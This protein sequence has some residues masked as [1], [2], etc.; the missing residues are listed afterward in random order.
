MF[1]FPRVGKIILPLETDR[2]V[3]LERVNRFVVKILFRG[4]ETFAH[5][6]ETGRLSEILKP[7]TSLLLREKNSGK[8]K[9]EVVAGWREGYGWIL[10]NSGFHNYIVSSLLSHSEQEIKV[11]R[12]RIDF[13]VGNTLIEVKGVT[14]FRG[15]TALFPDAPTE[16]GRKHVEII[17]KE[18]GMVIFLL[19]NP[20]PHFIVP[21]WEK[22]S[23]FGS[24]LVS[25]V[26]RCVDIVG[27]KVSVDSEGIYFGGRAVFLSHE[28]EEL[29]LLSHALEEYT[30]VGFI[31]RDEDILIGA[32]SP[33]PTH[34]GL[35]LKE[36]GSTFWRRFLLQ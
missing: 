26:R 15:D 13:K 6:R 23:L 14:L 36:I 8:Y 24:A 1:R 18:C 16:R 10:I 32:A 33:P 30:K 20:T 28:D 4:R 7:G 22:D 21:N 17:G 2:G 34:L 19:G 12:H 9:Y 35:R 25:S 31:L 11:D 5:L 27:L 3:F 29:K